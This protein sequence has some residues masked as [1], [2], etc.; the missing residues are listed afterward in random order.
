MDI[1][2]SDYILS[3]GFTFSIALIVAFRAGQT[4]ER[5]SINF[6]SKVNDL[7]INALH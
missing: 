5:N 1:L 7:T 6:E 3:L 4:R 2:V